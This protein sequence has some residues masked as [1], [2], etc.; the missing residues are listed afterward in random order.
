MSSKDCTLKIS[1]EAK[2]IFCCARVEMDLPI[3]NQIKEL[4]IQPID[5][6]KVI[7]RAILHGV[8]PL[9]YY[10]LNKINLNGKI[11][12][13]EIILKLKTYYYET[14]VRNMQFWKELQQILNA[15][16]QSKIKAIP[17]KGIILA[18]TLYRNIGL[19]PMIDIDLLIQE[20]DLSIFEKVIIELGYKKELEGYTENHWREYYHHFV[21]KRENA[22]H[23]PLQLEIHWDLSVPRPN[24]ILFLK[25]WQRTKQ[26]TIDGVKISLLSPEDTLLCL[27]LHLRRHTRSLILRHICD[28]YELLKQHESNFDW[29][30][31]IAE[32]DEIY[33]VFC[34]FFC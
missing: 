7:E 25:L 4:F 26:E 19:R 13:Q 6:N 10:N 11:I 32:V 27:A 28:I 31:V 20:S 1:N 24:K 17:I 3:Q 5:W 30:Y 29:N 21:F 14:L 15:L 22:A 33:P 23:F 18:E 16:E 8:G 2:L 12:P 34:P 9:I